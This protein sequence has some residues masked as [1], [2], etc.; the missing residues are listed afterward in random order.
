LNQLN[1]ALNQSPRD[2]NQ[3]PHG[4]NQ[5][6]R[7]SIH[8]PQDLNHPRQHSNRL[9]WRLPG[10]WHGRCTVR[11]SVLRPLQTVRRVLRTVRAASLDSEYPGCPPR[12]FRSRHFRSSWT[13]THRG[14]K[15]VRTKKSDIQQ[16]LDVTSLA[17]VVDG[18]CEAG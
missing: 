16:S 5:S 12:G 10:R 4:V 7:A 2:L 6:R 18:G 1:H 13:E 15:K 3:L 14:P 9:A 11:R 8:S 17:P